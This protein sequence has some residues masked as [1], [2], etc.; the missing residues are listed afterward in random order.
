MISIR[1]H[2]YSEQKYLLNV[3]QNMFFAFLA[4]A[5][6]SEALKHLSFDVITLNV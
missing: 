1:L 6:T 5:K 3:R 2:E 4:K